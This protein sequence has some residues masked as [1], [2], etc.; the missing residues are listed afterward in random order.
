[1]ILKIFKSCLLMFSVI[2]GVWMLCTAKSSGEPF[3]QIAGI[4][5]SV[6][7]LTTCLFAFK[8]IWT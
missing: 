1:M 7:F 2:V 6:V 4:L 8:R 5:V 3:I